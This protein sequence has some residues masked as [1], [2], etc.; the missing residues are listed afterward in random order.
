M[1]NSPSFNLDHAVATWREELARQPGLTPA[2]L[3][4]LEAHLRD[5][6]AELRKNPI[7]EE[8]AFLLA[9]LRVGPPKPVAFEFAKAAPQRVWAPKIFWLAF[10]VFSTQIWQSMLIIVWSTLYDRFRFTVW[11]PDWFMNVQADLLYFVLPILVA[12]YCLACGVPK[13]VLALLSS[14]VNVGILGGGMFLL[15]GIL[16]ESQGIPMVG[17][18][19][20]LAEVSSFRYCYWPLTLLA[21]M[22]WLTPRRV[23]AKARPS[24]A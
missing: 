23:A 6:F 5:G 13:S 4:E 2:D 15:I 16:Q 8:E 14:R 11:L 18:L 9:R 10:G 3:R 24:L 22:I 20:D 1:P 21:L 17:F 7:R 19:R 12:G